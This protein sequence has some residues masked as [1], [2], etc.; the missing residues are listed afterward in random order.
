MR[1]E[2]TIIRMKL[3]FKKWFP[4]TVIAIEM[5]SCYES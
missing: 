5:N 3:I 2:E 1:K 4:E